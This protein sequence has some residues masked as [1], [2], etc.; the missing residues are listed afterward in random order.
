MSRIA[1]ST[2]QEL[3]DRE[4][5]ESLFEALVEVAAHRAA[6]IVAADQREQRWVVGI[7]GL[8]RYLGGCSPRLARELR[9]KGMPARKVGKRLYF[10][11]REVDAFLEREGAAA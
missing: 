8:A 3:A 7:E 1:G 10:D 6:K 4:P 5:A 11:T 9:A 2:D